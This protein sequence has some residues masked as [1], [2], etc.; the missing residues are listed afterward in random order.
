MQ[1]FTWH[2]AL[3]FVD[4]TIVSKSNALDGMVW[5]GE[6]EIGRYRLKKQPQLWRLRGNFL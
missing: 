2:V 4:P 3:Y 5:V 1:M 6:T